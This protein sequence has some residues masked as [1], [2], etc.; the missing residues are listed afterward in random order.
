MAELEAQTGWS[1]ACATTIVGT[2]IGALNAA[3]LPPGDAVRPTTLEEL[4]ALASVAARLALPATTGVTPAI[5]RLRRFGGRVVAQVLPAGRHHA[6][7][8]VAA[9]PYHPGVIVVSVVRGSS[10][11]LGGQRRVTRL[12]D[13]EEPAAE[14]YASAAVPGFSEPVRVA[15]EA[16]IDGAVHSPTNADLVAPELHDALV[17]IAPMVARSGGSILARAHRSQL[18]DE[19]RPWLGTAKPVVLICPTGHEQARRHDHERFAAAA[20]DR[21]RAGTDRENETNGTGS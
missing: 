5:S 16:R 7:Y 14:L 13:A 17:V 20:V 18:M 2:S 12:V 11:H 1:A 15:G 6:D 19:I 4:S 8:P 3:R 9:P 21:L 10:R